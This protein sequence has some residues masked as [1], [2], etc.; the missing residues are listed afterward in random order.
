MNSVHKNYVLFTPFKTMCFVPDHYSV[1]LD[2]AEDLAEQGNNVDLVYCD[3]K[4]IQNCIYN[5]YGDKKVCKA[6]VS[7]Q[8][9]FHRHITH[10]DKI[11]VIPISKFQKPE[12]V[13]FE[14]F[15][16][17]L[18]YETIDDVKEITHKGAH[19]GLAAVSSY[20]TLSRNL[21]PLIDSEFKDF[22]NRYLFMSARTTDLVE[23]VI[24]QLHPDSVSCFNGRLIC[25]RPIVD[26]CINKGMPFQ[27]YEVGYNE[28]N[29]INKKIF[30][31]SLPH[32]PDV[33]TIM[34][35]ELW[36]SEGKSK[37]ERI[38]T[39]KRFFEKR[40]KAIVSGDKVA[41]TKNQSIGLLPEDWDNSKINISIFNSSED[42]FASLGEKFAKL[43]LFPSQ[44]TGIK[45]IFEKFKDNEEIH[46][47]LRVHPNL[48]N[49]KYKYHKSLY[50]LDKYKNVTIIPA[51]SKISTYTLVDSSDKVIVFGSSV[52]FEAAYANKP[53]IL[54]G[55]TMYRDLGI[56]YVAH[57]TDELDKY[58]I[59][60][61]LKPLDNLGALKFAYYIVNSEFP[62]PKYFADHKKT[63]K[64]IFGKKFILTRSVISNS[65][66]LSPYISYF[67]QI[68]GK[69]LW[70][71]SKCGY[72]TKERE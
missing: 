56:C 39:A 69:Y 68:I 50:E 65:K 27:T 10:K 18:K 66:T 30:N 49:V 57:T 23:E 38:A 55:C 21:D 46:F 9:Y 8:H 43:S 33:N 71:K 45:Y 3:G 47:Y 62:M 72:P 1:V 12:M 26:L 2:N 20:L 63:T 28:E 5:C 22:M 67:Y 11:N 31:N 53:V 42:E 14:S 19:I 32:D 41:Y 35:N 7:Y 54:L 6:C 61:D 64:K 60:K 59:D 52:G 58:I 17:S 34:I 4:A 15:V 29:R 70:S 37:E 48:T 44:L 40:R 36:E 13:D 51:D 16:K 24:N 25:N